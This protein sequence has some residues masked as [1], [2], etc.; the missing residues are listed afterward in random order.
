MKMNK[1]QLEHYLLLANLTIE[2][3]KEIIKAIEKGLK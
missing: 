3:L 1:E 2:Q